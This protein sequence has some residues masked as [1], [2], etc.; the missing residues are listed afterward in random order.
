MQYSI[1]QGQSALQNLPAE[2]SAHLLD[3]ESWFRCETSEG[4]RPPL[5]RLRALSAAVWLL[6]GELDVAHEVLLG[7]SLENIQQAE[8]AATHPGQTDWSKRYP[9][10][11]SIDLLHA[12]LHRFE[13]SE[14]G[15]GGH[16]GFQN[17]DYWF[18]GGPKRLETSPLHPSLDRL[19]QLA[20]THAPLC[21]RRFGLV[22]A[23]VQ[24]QYEILADGGKARRVQ[25]LPGQWDGF[26]FGRLCEQ[27]EQG[28]LCL[29][30]AREAA[31]L[32]HAEL[33]LL[34]RHELRAC[35]KHNGSKK[36]TTESK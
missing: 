12:C 5:S 23:D 15:E 22:V 16:S 7:V 33:V 31:L 13:G 25:V 8:Y 35:L 18:A 9:F 36:E 10:S 1:F 14:I 30:E 20:F 32:Q 6:R 19:A 2:S 29:E 17:A 26:A 4:S 21:T 11:T 28:N 34:L 3:P 24:R 27:W